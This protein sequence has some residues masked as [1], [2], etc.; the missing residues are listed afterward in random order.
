MNF[1]LYIPRKAL[2]VG[3]ILILISPLFGVIL[4]DMVGFHEPL[5]IA[6]EELN[7]PDW[8]EDLNWTPFLDYMIPNLSAEIGYIIAGFLG[9]ALILG[10][11]IIFKRLLK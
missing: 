4:A 9:F 1:S 11:G 3:V 8:T 6:A 2:M 7:L 10:V 5:D